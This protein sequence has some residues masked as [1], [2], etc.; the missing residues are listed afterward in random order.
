MKTVL[1]QNVPLQFRSL[2]VTVLHMISLFT[3]MV[4]CVPHV[5]QAAYYSCNTSLF[6]LECNVPRIQENSSQIFEDSHIWILEIFKFI[7]TFRLT[8][9][10]RILHIIYVHCDMFRPIFMT[11]ITVAAQFTSFHFQFYV[12]CD[13][14]LWWPKYRPKHVVENIKNILFLLVLSVW[15]YK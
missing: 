11:I 1:L 6:E 12:N 3:H 8:Q 4:Q 2:S 5:K 15:I 14:T 7:Y 9:L 13:T 10:T